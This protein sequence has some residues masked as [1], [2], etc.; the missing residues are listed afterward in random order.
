M[1]RENYYYARDWVGNSQNSWGRGGIGRLDDYGDG[2]VTSIVL[3]VIGA[4]LNVFSAFADVH[5]LAVTL[6][7]FSLAFAIVGVISMFSIPEKG[8]WYVSGWT[9]ISIL[10]FGY[11]LVYGNCVWFISIGVEKVLSPL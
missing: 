2:L 6:P 11:G 8:V 1:S 10:L 3:L 9:I 4:L 5:W 7:L